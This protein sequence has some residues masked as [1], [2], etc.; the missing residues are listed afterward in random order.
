VIERFT[1]ALCCS[2]FVE[3]MSNVAPVKSCAGL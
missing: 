1:K 2:L 3:S